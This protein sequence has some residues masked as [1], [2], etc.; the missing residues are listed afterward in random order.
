LGL[1]HTARDAPSVKMSIEERFKKAKP[2]PMHKV[3][4]TSRTL[5]DGFYKFARPGSGGFRAD[6]FERAQKNYLRSWAGGRTKAGLAARVEASPL[7]TPYEWVDVFAKSQRVK[8]LP[9]RTSNATKFQMIANMSP[10]HHMY[11]AV[12]ALY[13]EYMLIEHLR[14]GVLFSSRMSPAQMDRWYRRHWDPS[15]RVTYVD[16]TGWDTGVDA[17]FTSAYRT[18]YLGW[19]VPV[20]V[21][22]K[23]AYDR[24]HPRTFFG[25]LPEMQMS[26]DRF[27][28]LNNTIGNMMISGCCSSIPSVRHLDSRDYTAPCSIVCAFCGDDSIYCGLFEY[29]SPGRFGLNFI[30]KVSVRDVG[31]FCGFMF[32]GHRLHIDA[33]T[34]VHRGQILYSDGVNDPSVWL[35]Y[36]E[37]LRWAAD[38]GE[39]TPALAAAVEIS[40]QAHV[41]FNIPTSK[42]TP[43]RYRAPANRV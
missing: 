23:F 6:L 20:N 15:S 3:P 41:S 19:G 26:G 34:M 39:M 11:W 36:D 33:P 1:H 13:C 17:N 43:S 7:D 29:T 10:H 21:A 42:F 25:P 31:E 30:E 5:L 14:K 16:Y 22:D 18:V 12:W 38:V 37:Q 9:K 8:K 40:H 35:S 2:A 24:S 32:G 4:Q 28:L 27:T